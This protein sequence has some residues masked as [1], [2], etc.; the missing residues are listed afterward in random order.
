[1]QDENISEMFALIFVRENFINLFNNKAEYLW[2]YEVSI[3]QK[4]TNIYM[5]E[6][7]FQNRNYYTVYTRNW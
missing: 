4:P 1:M 7:H 6:R 5:F 3:S 2:H